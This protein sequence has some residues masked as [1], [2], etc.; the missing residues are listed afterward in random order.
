L[1]LPHDSPPYLDFK[2]N[3]PNLGANINKGAKP[4]Y[5]KSFYILQLDM[6]IGEKMICKGCNEP[7]P[8][9][10]SECPN[11]G[12]LV[13]EAMLARNWKCPECGRM[14]G[15]E[16]STCWYCEKRS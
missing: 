9:G 8:P 11:C 3:L 2:C 10:V 5:T 6:Y 13:V 12:R 15:P 1:F 4:V 16:R 7:L 14:N